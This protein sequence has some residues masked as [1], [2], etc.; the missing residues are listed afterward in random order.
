MKYLNEFKKEVVKF[1]KTHTIQETKDAY[2]VSVHSILTWSNPDTLER[3]KEGQKK[4]YRKVKDTKEYK[5]RLTFRNKQN[6]AKNKEKIRLENNKRYKRCRRRYIE[7]NKKWYKDNRDELRGYY[8]RRRRNLYNTDINF[9]LKSILRTRLYHALRGIRKKHDTME[10]IGCE[11]ST[12]KE[13]L[14]SQFK[15]G[16]SWENY[17]DWHVDHIRPCSSFDL[18]KNE[19]QQKCFHYSNLQPLWAHENLK[20]SNFIVV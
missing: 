5:E 13:H 4:H 14:E 2:G 19:E 15:P 3:S 18:T 1:Y 16:M 12:L 17:G 9:K 6:Y 7:Q 10:L 11:L 8:R 20:K